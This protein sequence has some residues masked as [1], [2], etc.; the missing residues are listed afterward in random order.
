[1]KPD[2]TE[3]AHILDTDGNFRVIRRLEERSRY[4]DDDGSEK[5]LGIYLDVECTGLDYARE[6]IIE[7]GMIRFEYSR[8]GKIFRVLE[9]FDEY[10]DPGVPIPPFITALTGITD[11]MVDGKRIDDGAV[12]AFI[13]DASI[14]IAHNAGFDRK[15]ME[16]RFPMFAG[17]SWGCSQREVPWDEEGIESFKL[18]YIAYRMGFFYEG[19]RADI[20]CRAGLEALSRPLPR[21]NQLPLAILL[22]NAGKTTYLIWAIGSPY[23]TKDILRERGYRWSPGGDGRLKSWYKEVDSDDKDAEIK[24]LKDEIYVK[25]VEPRVD[26]V[27][28]LERYSDRV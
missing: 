1:M 6:S 5:F 26:K 14:V 9:T 24:Y 19:H 16:K 15:F 22:E 21:S 23:E 8:E 17:K 13:E 4:N 7:L 18:E 25:A 28:A 2:P 10:E 3:L 20:D 27:T 12:K 11:E